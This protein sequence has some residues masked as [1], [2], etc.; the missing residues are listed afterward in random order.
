MLS[1][2]ENIGVL[3]V[4][5]F[6]FVLLLPLAQGAERKTLEGT[7]TDAMCGATHKAG[8]SAAACTNG[9]VNMGSKYALVVGDTV[10]T[11]EGKSGE[12]KA[13][14]GEKVKLTGTVDGKAVQ[15]ESVGKS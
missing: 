13:L 3:G 11:L 10:Y 15:V 1:W 4:A 2:K 6:G 9:C 5:L 8:M 12:L 14:A 7:I